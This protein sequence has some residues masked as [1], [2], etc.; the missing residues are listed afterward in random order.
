MMQDL[1]YSIQI[2]LFRDEKFFGPGIVELLQRV[3]QRHSLR[4]AAIEMGMAY[5]KAWRLIKTAE[6]NL[7]CKLLNSTTGGKGGGGAELTQECRAFMEKYLR[8]EAQV[9]AYSE[10]AFAHVFQN[11]TT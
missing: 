10:K 3:D 7:E 1:H 8:F 5:S 9:R 4:A 11:E 6:E 2:R